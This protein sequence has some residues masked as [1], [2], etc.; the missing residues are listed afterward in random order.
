MAA[1][2]VKSGASVSLAELIRPTAATAEKI[3]PALIQKVRGALTAA[4]K[5]K[6]GLGTSQVQSVKFAE[7]GSAAL[8]TRRDAIRKQAAIALGVAFTQGGEEGKK[9]AGEALAGAL[10]EAFEESKLR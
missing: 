8:S 3:G 9:R 4:E 10:D 7:S 1:G 6:I 5:A 2:P